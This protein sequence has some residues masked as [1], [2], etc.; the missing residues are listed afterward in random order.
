MEGGRQLGFE[1][2][3]R[4]K[5]GAVLRLA[6]AEATYEILNVMEYSSAR[7]RM[8][9]VAKAPSGAVRLY[10]KGADSKVLGI[11]GAGVGRGL[12]DA[13]QA[14]LH[15][16]ATQVRGG[17]RGAVRCTLP[18]H[19]PVCHA[20]VAGGIGELCAEAFLH[21]CACPPADYCCRHKQESWLLHCLSALWHPSCTCVSL[22]HA[23]SRVGPRL[24]RHGAASPAGCCV[25]TVDQNIV[26]ERN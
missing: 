10:C 19:A 4:I 26:H 5:D 21:A 1:F 13:T 9:V 6:G 3:K 12:L 23:C 2:V 15:L 8:S 17:H 22:M 7:G 11:L 25:K 24:L 20:G 14:N 18:L 16:F